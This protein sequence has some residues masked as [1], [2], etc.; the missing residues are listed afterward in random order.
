MMSNGN[1][2]YGEIPVLERMTPGQFKKSQ[3]LYY[4]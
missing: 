1:I 3:A 4:D 2:L